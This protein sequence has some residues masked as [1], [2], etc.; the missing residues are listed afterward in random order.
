MGHASR[1]LE[2]FRIELADG[3]AGRTKLLWLGPLPGD[4]L[5]GSSS[6]PATLLV[7]GILLRWMLMLREQNSLVPSPVHVLTLW[8]LLCT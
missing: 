4:A 6:L 1:Y 5:H 3:S 8:L 7:A 2:R